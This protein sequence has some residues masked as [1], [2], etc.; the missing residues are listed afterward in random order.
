MNLLII[1]KFCIKRSDFIYIDDA[2]SCIFFIL[3]FFCLFAHFC[4]FWLLLISE[5]LFVNL[6]WVV[7]FI[8][9]LLR[10]IYW[11]FLLFG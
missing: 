7:S 3:F 1:V 5:L 10:F 2:D 9:C 4:S 11:V 6:W 8:Y